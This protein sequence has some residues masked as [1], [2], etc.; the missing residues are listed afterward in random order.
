M[1]K[2]FNRPF[3]KPSAKAKATTAPMRKSGR[4]PAKKPEMK[5]TKKAVAMYLL[6]QLAQQKQVQEIYHAGVIKATEE[7]NRRCEILGQATERTIRRK[8]DRFFNQATADTLQSPKFMPRAHGM[9]N[10][11]AG[12]IGSTGVMGTQVVAGRELKRYVFGKKITAIYDESMKQA[13][14]LYPETRVIT[15]VLAEQWRGQLHYNSGFNCKGFVQPSGSFPTLDT[16]AT[17]NP[18]PQIMRD[19]TGANNGSASSYSMFFNT[20]DYYNAM[21]QCTGSMPT[22]NAIDLDG[23]EGQADVFYAL[24]SIRLEADI[25]NSNSFYPVQVKI[26]VLRALKNM[27]VNHTPIDRYTGT[28]VPSYPKSQVRA[29]VPVQYLMYNSTDV[30]GDGNV[31]TKTMT[32]N[33]QLSVLPQVT[34]AMSE[35]F[36]RSYEVVSVDKITLDP[37]ESLTYI[38]EKQIPKPT[39][40]RDI[41]FARHSGD[42]VQPGDFGLMIEFQGAQCIAQPYECQSKTRDDTTK[43]NEPV[44]GLAPSR[45]RVDTKKSVVVCAAAIDSTMNNV[46]ALDSGQATWIFQRNFAPNIDTSVVTFDYDN[47][48]SSVTQGKFTLPVYTDETKQNAGPI[49]D[50]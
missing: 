2:P 37:L 46:E 18:A 38:L 41:Q 36:K 4:S 7:I 34:P 23:S 31:A 29:K 27:T 39:S 11:D 20:S 43:I 22:S 24:R 19:E 50:L 32:Y 17:S 28:T 15:D 26:F 33:D 25:F 12:A 6:Q 1:I 40:L 8:F 35:R 9:S 21:S 3:A 45:L 5:L 48:A 47:L 14:K 30:L 44:M 16:T 10:S 49:T 13:A 42:Y